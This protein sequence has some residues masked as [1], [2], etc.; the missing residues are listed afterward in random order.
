MGRIPDSLLGQLARTGGVGPGKGGENVGRATR[1]ARAPGVA[2]RQAVARWG[3][4]GT[5]LSVDLPGIGRPLSS[6][7]HNRL[8]PIKNDI[9]VNLFMYFHVC[10]YLAHMFCTDFISAVHAQI[11]RL[12][13][14]NLRNVHYPFYLS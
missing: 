4:G 11:N 8:V 5:G 12:F 14:I 1:C 2:A 7:V 9:I 3:K 10:L 6:R 13:P